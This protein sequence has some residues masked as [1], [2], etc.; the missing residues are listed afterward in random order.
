MLALAILRVRKPHGQSVTGGLSTLANTAFTGAFITVAGVSCGATITLATGTNCTQNIA[1][2]P[3]APGA[4][5]GS[6]VFGG[7]GVVPQSIL[8]TV[9]ACRP[10]RR[11]SFLLILPRRLQ[12]K[13]SSSPR[14]F[15]LPADAAAHP[16][17]GVAAKLRSHWRPEG[18]GSGS[19]FF[20]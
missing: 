20:G 19:G 16:F 9:P 17:R 14:P 15:S 8:L 7:T 18:C 2:L 10:Q 4:A 1:F 11:L 12:A 13:P 3:T 5:S 6:V